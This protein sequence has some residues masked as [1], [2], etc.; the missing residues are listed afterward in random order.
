MRDNWCV[1]YSRRYTVGVWVG[2]FSGEPMRDVSGVSGAAPIWSEVM[3]W[4]HRA[5][6]SAPPEPPGGIRTR[7]VVFPRGVETD[8]IEW[9][10]AGTEAG[11]GVRAEGDGPPR[12]ITPVSGTRIALDPDI[13]PDRQR[14]VFEAQGAGTS[15]RWT[16]NGRELGPASGLVLW[17]PVAGK[18]TLALVDADLRVRHAATFEVRGPL[19]EQ[20]G[21]S[22]TTLEGEEAPKER[23]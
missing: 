3:A 9:F 13:P 20:G 8:R 15:L 19:R 1:G 2:N 4:L 11:T 23:E 12:I 18:H 10:I 14:V 6:R 17:E 16:L 7:A 22:E 21:R 5:V